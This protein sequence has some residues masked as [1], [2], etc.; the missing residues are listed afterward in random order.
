VGNRLT[1]EQKRFYESEGYLS[2]LPVVF[3]EAEVKELQAVYETVVSMLH[4]D[5]IPSDIMQWHRTS[6]RLYDLCTH[7]QILDYVE[8]ILGPDFFLWGSEFITKSPH[9]DRTVGWHQDAYYWALAPH[10]SVTVWLAFVDVDP[11]NGAMQVIPG[12]HKAGL[13][14]H[15]I[16]DEQSILSF[17]LEQGSFS[18]AD[19]VT[20]SIPAGGMTLHDDAIVHGSQANRSDRWRIGFVIRYSSTDVKSDM[21]RN[22]NFLS[23]MVRGTD[24]YGHNPQGAIPTEPFARPDYSKRIRKT[25]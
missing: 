7:P 15:Q 9:S 16:S 11:E 14:K 23:Y 21:E 13:I 6:K 5:E 4:E 25:K 18:A 2:G 24:R 10:N 22:P 1:D 17:E 19:A 12:S 20:L 8:G 3:D